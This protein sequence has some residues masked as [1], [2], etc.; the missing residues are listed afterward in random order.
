MYHTSDSAVVAVD[1]FVERQQRYFHKN[2]KYNIAAHYVVRPIPD[3]YMNTS[4]SQSDF[5]CSS[6]CSLWDRCT[7]RCEKLRTWPEYNTAHLHGGAGG[8][9]GD[10]ATASR[11]Y[12]GGRPARFSNS[13]AIGEGCALPARSSLICAERGPPTTYYPPQPRIQRSV[14]QQQSLEL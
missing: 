8:G 1:S 2:S 12:L 10:A 9:G 6:R 7:C 11:K 3:K 13:S 14:Q 5:S 4:T